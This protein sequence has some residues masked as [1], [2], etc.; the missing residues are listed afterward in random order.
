[1]HGCSGFLPRR[2]YDKAAEGAIRV[3]QACLQGTSALFRE[4][5]VCPLLFT[6]YTER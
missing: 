1:M 5:P 4:E 3:P 6:L 2:N